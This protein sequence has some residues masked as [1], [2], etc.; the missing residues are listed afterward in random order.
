MLR[1]PLNGARSAYYGLVCS[2]SQSGSPLRTLSPNGL[3]MSNW[4][5]PSCKELCPNT[6]SSWARSFYFTSLMRGGAV[7][8]SNFQQSS[9]QESLDS[10]PGYQ[11]ANSWAPRQLVSHWQSCS[12]IC[13][14]KG[15]LTICLIPGTNYFLKTNILFAFWLSFEWS[16]DRS[17]LELNIPWQMPRVQLF[18]HILVQGRNILWQVVELEACCGTWKA[19]WRHTRD[20]KV[21]V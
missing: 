12:Y 20:G 1:P 13:H 2:T 11:S 4:D 14:V 7:H 10:P 8:T 21:L 16:L 3:T 17:T 9:K 15:I 18:H 5:F 19:L 6:T